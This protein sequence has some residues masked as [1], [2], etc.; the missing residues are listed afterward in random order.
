MCVQAVISQVLKGDV[1]PATLLGSQ[2][3]R[4]EQEGLWRAPQP[5][6]GRPLSAPAKIT[7]EVR[8]HLGVDPAHGREACSLELSK[9]GKH[10]NQSGAVTCGFL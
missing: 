2:G 5:I 10:A 3:L 6:S 7:R 8:G 9:V 4:V 1:H